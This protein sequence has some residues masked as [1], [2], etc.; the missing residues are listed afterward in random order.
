MNKRTRS[1]VFMAILIAI[2]LLFGF[3]PIGYIP[4]PFARL[5]LM[6]LPVIIGTMVLGLRTGFGLSLVFIMTSIVQL[7]TAPDA[8]SVILFSDNP[9]AYIFCLVLPRLLIAPVTYGVQKALSRRMAK[10]SGIL[11]AVLG[12]LVN[13]FGYLGMLQIIF[14]PAL[15]AGL[16]MD[17]SAATVMIWTVVL[18]NG[19]PEAGIA[20]V[21]CPLISNAVKKSIPPIQNTKEKAVA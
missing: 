8:V 1:L 12:S 18:T 3:T 2:M 9:V 11:A 5:T 19:L 15:S 16:S 20:G 17:I 6:C 10:G 21:L 4:L 7:L 13:T 14:V